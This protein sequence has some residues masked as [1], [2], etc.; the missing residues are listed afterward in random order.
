MKQK[1]E[2]KM[3]HNAL[4]KFSE[5]NSTTKCRVHKLYTWKVNY[6]V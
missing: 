5:K 6:H 1:I 2:K 3:N 4:Y